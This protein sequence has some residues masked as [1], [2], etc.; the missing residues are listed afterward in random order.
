MNDVVRH[1]A[2]ECPPR[3]R[4]PRAARPLQ[5]QT[6]LDPPKTFRLRRPRVFT[7][8]SKTF[9]PEAQDFCE[10]LD[11][12]A[13]DFG[14]CSFPGALCSFRGALLPGGTVQLPGALLPGSYT[15]KSAPRRGGTNSRRARPES[16][17]EA[18][19]GERWLCGGPGLLSE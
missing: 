9:D 1:T 13:Q 11:S 6:T 4:R 12:E 8:T 10:I 18:R 7:P 14:L 16:T 2:A 5:M 19:S 15:D 3:N 17:S